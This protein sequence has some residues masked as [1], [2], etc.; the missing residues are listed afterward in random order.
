MP[1]N[2]ANTFV[3]NV[4]GRSLVDRVRAIQGFQNPAPPQIFTGGGM[5]TF[6]GPG[7]NSFIV[8]NGFAVNCR[9]F[10]NTTAY[11]NN[12]TFEKVY[13]VCGTPG[14]FSLRVA[15][16]PALYLIAQN[17]TV[18]IGDI[19]TLVDV[20]NAACWQ[21]LNGPCTETGSVILT[22]KSHPGLALTIRSDTEIVMEA[23][24]VDQSKFCLM[25][26]RGINTYSNVPD[27][28]PAVFSDYDVRERWVL[29]DMNR[30]FGPKEFRSY[31]LPPTSARTVE[32]C[33]A[34]A[35]A[36]KESNGFVFLPQ[37]SYDGKNCKIKAGGFWP[38]LRT[39]DPNWRN[40]ISGRL[41]VDIANSYRDP[42]ADFDI[43]R[44][45][46]VADINLTYGSNPSYE[47]EQ[48]VTRTP[49]ECAAAALRNPKANS[50]LFVPN[51]DKPCRMKVGGFWPENQEP[52]HASYVGGIIKSKA[53]ESF[54]YRPGFTV[55][56]D[57]RSYGD[58]PSYE[59]KE[60]EAYSPE[61][62]AE[63]ALKNDKVNGFIYLPKRFSADKGNCRQ[64]IGG[65]WG[66]VSNEAQ[67][68]FTA[69]M[70]KSMQ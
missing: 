3:R 69:G 70:K 44:G 37:G 32:E 12:G 57:N 9:N 63:I 14:Y 5:V 1:V 22:N 26:E 56:N 47:L 53:P 34:A 18:T 7:R 39:Q 59:L 16:A 4:G 40:T 6:R 48:T 30:S 17:S 23:P 31:E 62:C 46:N 45:W 28:R 65:R 36:I 68:A 13:P 8:R 19:N 41:K 29:A 52:V 64:F 60:V 10:E 54:D 33:A 35:S 20:Q 61:N 58:N 49:E 11:R 55:H 25:E 21:T 51:S 38:T 42:I 50:F 24:G 27:P 15:S 66:P 43:R 2:S 67:N